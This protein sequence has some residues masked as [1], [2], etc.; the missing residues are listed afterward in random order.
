[1]VN[2]KEEEREDE[3]SER[4]AIPF[5]MI[6]L[7]VDSIEGTRVVHEDHSRYCETTESIQR[8]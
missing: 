6:E 2:D 1:M 3:I 7:R 4:P 5:G 8:G